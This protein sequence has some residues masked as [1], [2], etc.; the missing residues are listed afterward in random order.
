MNGVHRFCLTSN[1]LFIFKVDP[2]TDRPEYYEF[3]L[4]SIRRCGHTF[5]T[6]FIELGRSSSIGPGELWIQAGDSTI[7]QNMHEVILQAM[8]CSKNNEE[9]G[10][11]QRPRSASTS[12][13]PISTRRP[14]QST[15]TN[16][17]M[18]VVFGPS[19]SSTTS[20]SAVMT[21]SANKASIRE[22]C[23]SM[24]SRSRTNSESDSHDSR[25]WTP[26]HYHTNHSGIHPGHRTLS[27]SPPSLNP[28]GYFLFYLNINLEKLFVF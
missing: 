18:G 17:N 22:R 9:F 28:L 6:F 15:H 20:G 2:Q 27:Y 14:T 26:V 11:S 24:P 1:T 19:Y 8:C 4:I 25:L 5:S 7:A 10:P 12:D 3:P 16:P 23:D 13:K 21:A